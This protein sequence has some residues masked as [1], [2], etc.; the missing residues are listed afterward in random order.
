M[1]NRGFTLLE[2]ML[3]M[4]IFAI[5]GFA[6][7]ALLDAVM[8]GDEASQQ[9]QQRLQKLQQ[10][11]MLMDRDF[12]QITPRQI[13]VNGEA[14]GKAVLAGGKNWIESD[15]DGVTLTHAGWSNPG[16]VLPRSEVQLVGYRVQ[17]KQL[18]RLYYIYPDAVTGTEPRVQVLMDKVEGLKIRYMDA[19][20]GDGVG[21][22]SSDFDSGN[23]F[24][25]GGF[26]SD[27]N[28]GTS[29][30]SSDADDENGNW[31]ETWEDSRLPA[32]IKITIVHEQLGEID[33]VFTM[34]AG[35][36]Q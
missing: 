22:S 28:G 5:V 6:S 9:A 4:A 13:R 12:W 8:R 19:G 26:S 1:R 36:T 23:D 14:P 10:S 29:S 24:S 20:R 31:L 3:A 17:E 2:L 33:R 35:L 15:D 11:F 30:A 27:R 34:P 16:A 7:S 32:L 21:G 18:Q 25:T